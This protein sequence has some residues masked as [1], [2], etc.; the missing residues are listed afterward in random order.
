MNG[1]HDG[2]LRAILSESIELIQALDR[3]TLFEFAERHA[4]GVQDF[5]GDIGELTVK[6]CGDVGSPCRIPL[7]ES[8]L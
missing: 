6:P 4:G 2:R 3:H 5:H 7:G 1:Q 8:I